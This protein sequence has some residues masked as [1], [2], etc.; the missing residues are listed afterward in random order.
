MSEPEPEA[1]PEAGAAPKLEPSSDAA[2]VYDQLSFDRAP[3]LRTVAAG[4]PS[5][6]RA[7]L[8]GFAAAV[9]GAVV[10]FVVLWLTGYQ[11]GLISIAVGIAVGVA[12]RTGANG[13]SHRG[14]RVLAVALA[15]FSV[16]LTYVPPLLAEF[17]HPSI[18]AVIAS[19]LGAL[20]VPIQ[21]LL[22]GEIMTAVIAGIA[23]WE[24]WR[25]SAPQVVAVHPAPPGP[26][27][28]PAPPAP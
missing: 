27:A 22:G 11:L 4:E 20:T 9:L 14:F 24:A 2:R 15:Y 5:V 13:S 25:F 21:Q 8:L 16:A 28:P 3:V 10:F 26:P 7:V 1:R 12:V 23:L 6:A 17:P 19:V 18:L